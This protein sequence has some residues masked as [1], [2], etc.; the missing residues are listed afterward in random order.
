MAKKKRYLVQ[1]WD[2]E[3]QRF[4]PQEGVDPGPHT[5]TGVR[6]A[7]KQ[8]RALGYSATED[9]MAESDP[10]VAVDEVYV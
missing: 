7:L 9:D 3:L 6:K 4:T 1:T 5:L 10:S 2:T 8:L